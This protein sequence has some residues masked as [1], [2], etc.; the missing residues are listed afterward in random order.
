MPRLERTR[1]RFAALLALCLLG[2]V[3][4]RSENRNPLIGEWKLVKSDCQVMTQI[5]YT[6]TQYAGFETPAGIYPGWRTVAVTYN[7][8]DPKEVWIMVNGSGSNET[9]VFV[10]DPNH[11]KPDDGMGCI[12]E[13]VK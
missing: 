3:A 2:A 11:I 4:C 6:P 10:L 13:R 8:A 5:K 1:I 7:F 12:Y 9:R